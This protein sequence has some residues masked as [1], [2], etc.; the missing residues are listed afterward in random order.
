MIPIRLFEPM[1]QKPVQSCGKLGRCLRLEPLEALPSKVALHDTKAFVSSVVVS[2]LP[3]ANGACLVRGYDM[4]NGVVLWRSTQTEERSCFVSGVAVN[5]KAVVLSGSGGSNNP[6]ELPGGVF[7]AFAFDAETGVL[8]W[9][10]RGPGT[11]RR[12]SCPGGGH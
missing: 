7:I 10:D 4:K 8:L 6:E 2:S 1:P 3:R 11:P 12:G 5:T 9:S